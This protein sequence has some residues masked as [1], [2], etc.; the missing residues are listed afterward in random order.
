[1][2]KTSTLEKSGEGIAFMAKR[3]KK[4]IFTHGKKWL[5]KLAG[6]FQNLKR[7]MKK[8]STLE[9][10]GEGIAFM[11]K[12]VKKKIFTHGKKWLKKLAGL[13]QREIKKPYRKTVLIIILILICLFFYFT[14][15]SRVDRQAI[16]GEEINILLLGTDTVDVKG[17]TDTI[18][19]VSYEPKI[20]CLRVLF[21]PRDT[22][23]AVPYKGGVRFDKINHI[24]SRGGVKL[25]LSLIEELMKEDI[26]FYGVVG[27][28]GFRNMVDIV[29]GVEVYI[30]RAMR[31]T[32]RAGELYIN[33]PAGLQRLDGEKVLQ[34]IRYRSDTGDIGRIERQ[35]KIIRLFTRKLTRSDNPILTSSRVLKELKKHL[36][37]NFSL[38]DIISLASYIKDI[39]FQRVSMLSACGEPRQVKGI[40][41]WQV[42]W[43]ETRVRWESLRE[44]IPPTAPEG[45][46][47]VR[48]L[49]GCG[50]KGVARELQMR[51]RQD[52]KIDVLEVGNADRFTYD[53]TLIVDHI[54][55]RDKAR[56]VRKI[57]GLGRICKDIDPEVL[58]DVTIIIG[59]DF[60]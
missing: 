34:Y 32:D 41:H 1:M 59:R 49:N 46:V 4:K 19:L 14:G 38:F 25:L 54:G 26:L 27:Y 12:R 6:L 8:T 50:K 11:A 20:Q 23:I 39:D 42:D 3:V 53:E 47:R 28:A 35:Q 9:K 24:Y 22:L 30:P 16:W 43:E 2:K 55:E 56:Y 37:T 10:S 13:F 29:G 5:K 31:Y 18:L 36:L 17:R 60:Q 21:I 40:A 7:S 44:K 52:K 58:V 15:T 45:M 51:L 33:I 57:L 48:L